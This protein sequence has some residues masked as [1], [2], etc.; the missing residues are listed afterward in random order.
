MQLYK[1]LVVLLPLTPE[2]RVTTHVMWWTC[3]RDPSPTYPPKHS[4]VPKVPLL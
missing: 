3:V 4:F 1:V 2:L